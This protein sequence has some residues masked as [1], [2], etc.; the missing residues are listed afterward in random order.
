MVSHISREY[1]KDMEKPSGTERVMELGRNV[2]IAFTLGF[3]AL[4]LAAPPAIIG[5]YW[6]GAQAAG[7]EAGRRWA[8]KRKKKKG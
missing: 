5:V 8:K 3:A 4:T 2:N 1:N 6:N 7:F